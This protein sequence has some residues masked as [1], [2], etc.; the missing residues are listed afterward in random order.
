MIRHQRPLST[1]YD[2]LLL[3]NWTLLA[4]DVI[5][6]CT[7]NLYLMHVPHSPFY[8][9]MYV[10]LI[11]LCYLQ[12]I[13]HPLVPL[14]QTYILTP[15][16]KL[17][18]GTLPHMKLRIFI[19]PNLISI[20]CSLGSLPKESLQVWGSV[21]LFVTGSFFTVR[22]CYS[23][24]QPLSLMSTPCWLY[25]SAYSF[26]WQLF[27]IRN[28]RTHHSLMTGPRWHGEVQYL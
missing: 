7:S 12:P 9:R 11:I 19:M 25:P 14:N 13:W 26:Y 2:I 5:L 18:L 10:C 20:F 21:K 3:M 28:L 17:S 23:H 22:S 6:L 24:A 16:S 4:A 27:S 15:L 8:R 1:V